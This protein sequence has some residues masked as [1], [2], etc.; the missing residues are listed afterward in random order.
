VDN[1]GDQ[2]VRSRASVQNALLQKGALLSQ[3]EL[4]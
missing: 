4:S 2:F 1:F 3:L